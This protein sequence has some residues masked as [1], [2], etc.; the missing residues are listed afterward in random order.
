[1][2]RYH[3]ATASSSAVN[4]RGEVFVHF[5]AVAMKHHSSMWN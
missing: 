5:H 1:M 2:A 3:D 4:V